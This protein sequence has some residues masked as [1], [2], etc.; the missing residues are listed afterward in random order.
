[1]HEL[2][3]VPDP[4][5]VGIKLSGTLTEDDH[6]A[7]VGA[8]EHTMES[9]TTTRA[10]FELEDVDG[11][12]PEDLW[13]DLSFDIR[14]VQTLDKAVVVGDLWDPWMDKMELIFPAS[15]IETSGDREEALSWLRGEMEVPGIGP[16][17]VPDPDADAQDE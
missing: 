3:D 7:L 17:S 4:N 15:R 16:G 8:L 9:H 10:L 14:H 2:L 13:E 5:I 11:W 6:D 12:E 1:M